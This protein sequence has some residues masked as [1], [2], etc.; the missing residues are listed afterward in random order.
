MAARTFTRPAV[1]E[2]ARIRANG[3]KCVLPK[4]ETLRASQNMCEGS[5]EGGGCCKTGGAR[6]ASGW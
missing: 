1:V 3:R 2:R 5:G 4:R 6:R